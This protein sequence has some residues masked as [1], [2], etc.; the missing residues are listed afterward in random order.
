[1]PQAQEPSPRSGHASAYLQNHVYVLGGTG[2]SGEVLGDIVA[3]NTVEMFWSDATPQA[4]EVSRT[5]HTVDAVPGAALVRLSA[6][7]RCGGAR[8][9]SHPMVV[10]FHDAFDLLLLATTGWL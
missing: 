5:G 9:G 2:P 4:G 8:G 6:G 1:M 7:G 10:S 3:L